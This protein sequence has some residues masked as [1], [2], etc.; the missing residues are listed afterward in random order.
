MVAFE[1]VWL[2]KYNLMAMVKLLLEAD[3]DQSLKNLD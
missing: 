2:M 3:Q 1:D